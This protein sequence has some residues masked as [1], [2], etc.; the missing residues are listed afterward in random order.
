LD[1]EKIIEYII[2]NNNKWSK[3]CCSLP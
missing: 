2:Y 1:C 3:Y